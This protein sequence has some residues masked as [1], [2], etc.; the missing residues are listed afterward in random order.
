MK[1]RTAGRSSPHEP[2]LTHTALWNCTKDAQQKTIMTSLIVFS[3][4]VQWYFDV[5]HQYLPVF[6]SYVVL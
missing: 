6:R 3:Y 2:T 4:S 1:L 5:V